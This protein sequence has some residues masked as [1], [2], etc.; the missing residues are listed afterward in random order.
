MR[1]LWESFFPVLAVKVGIAGAYGWQSVQEEVHEGAF[2]RAEFAEHPCDWCSG[3]KGC[4]RRG[5]LG[6]PTLPVAPG[7]SQTS[8]LPHPG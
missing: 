1:F 6:R 8:P 5:G 7:A 4:V 3:T 2:L